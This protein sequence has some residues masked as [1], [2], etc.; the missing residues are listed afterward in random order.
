M[1]DRKMMSY[2]ESK[3]ER[4]LKEQYKHFCKTDHV[5]MCG[6]DVF[7]AYLYSMFGMRPK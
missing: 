6:K 2:E 4:L 1:L 5:I 3:S 7:Y